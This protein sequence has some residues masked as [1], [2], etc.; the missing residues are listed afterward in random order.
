MANLSRFLSWGWIIQFSRELKVA[1]SIWT[2]FRRIGIC[3]LPVADYHSKP[4]LR[5][6]PASG[7]EKQPYR[8]IVMPLRRT[9]TEILSHEEMDEL[10]ARYRQQQSDDKINENDDERGAFIAKLFA[11]QEAI[12]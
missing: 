6:I 5:G 8:E 11:E 3:F 7:L 12:T 4:K 10:L 2:V 1:A 9:P